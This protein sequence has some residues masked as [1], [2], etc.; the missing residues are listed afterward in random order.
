[1][2]KH[3]DCEWFFGDSMADVKKMD[4]ALLTHPVHESKTKKIGPFTYQFGVLST[5]KNPYAEYIILPDTRSISSWLFLLISRMLNKKVH[6]WTHGWYGKESKLEALLKKIL[7]RLPTGYI[8]LYGNYAKKLMIS[9]GFPENKL[10]TIHNSLLYDKQIEIR[11]SLKLN[12]TYLDH[13]KNDARNLIFVGRLTKVKSLDMLL[14][15]LKI[16]IDRGKSYNLTFI[17][18]G[19]ELK[20]LMTLAQSLSIENNVWFY[21][22]CYNEAELGNLIY[23]ADLCVS[24]GNIGLTAMHSMVYGTPALTHND[25]KWQMPEFEAIRDG[26]TGGFFDYGDVNALANSID[27]WFDK[28]NGNREAVRTA[29]F[30]EIDKYWTPYYQLNILNEVINL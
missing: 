25:F 21:G 3:F 28:H 20:S 4:Y 13:F 17:G 9:N 23:N 19:Q 11:K 14:N 1:M 6:V 8:L 5:L 29:C 27:L 22:P 10:K 12:D 15:A 2:D 18:G 7:F 30:E 16:C 24:P 26:V